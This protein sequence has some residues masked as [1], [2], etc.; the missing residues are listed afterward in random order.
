M[1]SQCANWRA[2]L[3]RS[4]GRRARS[5]AASRR[6]TRRPSRRCRRAGCARESRSRP[7]ERPVSSGFRNRAPPAPRRSPRCA[8]PDSMRRRRSQPLILPQ[9]GLGCPHDA[10][11]GRRCRGSVLDRRGRHLGRDRPAG[12]RLDPRL[13]RD[14][15]VP[16]SPRTPGL[17]AGRSPAPEAQAAAVSRT[18][19]GRRGRGRGGRFPA[20]VP[21]RHRASGAARLTARRKPTFDGQLAHPVPLGFR[22]LLRHRA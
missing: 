14:P 2:D 12:P 9:T 10:L 15:G 4:P 3:A 21:A 16:P 22:G 19:R 17:L 7:P 1:S 11:V 8:W 13:D 5:P 18:R 20:R 6:R